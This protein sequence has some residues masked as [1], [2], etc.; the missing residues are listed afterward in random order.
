MMNDDFQHTFEQQL[1]SFAGIEDQARNGSS[2]FIKLRLFRSI[3]AVFEDQI[4]FFAALSVEAL[5][6]EPRFVHSHVEQL[7]IQKVRISKLS[8]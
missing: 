5:R 2:S 1:D 7:T 4:D 8:S 6:I 3:V